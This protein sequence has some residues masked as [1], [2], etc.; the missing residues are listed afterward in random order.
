MGGTVSSR[1]FDSSRQLSFMPC[2]RYIWTA[3]GMKWA[4]AHVLIVYFFRLLCWRSSDDGDLL[5]DFILFFYFLGGPT[6]LHWVRACRGFAR[7]NV[8]SMRPAQ[9]SWVAD[10]KRLPARNKKNRFSNEIQNELFPLF[11]A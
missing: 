5:C 11:F 7:R 9:V 4:R 2:R 1:P 3:C 6:F 8:M 10:N